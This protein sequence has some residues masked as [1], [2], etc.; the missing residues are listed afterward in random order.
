[1][2]L[3]FCTLCSVL[4]V[5]AWAGDLP[6]AQATIYN[7]QTYDNPAGPAFNQ[8]L[9][10]NNNGTIAGYYGSGAAGQP[11]NGYILNTPNTYTNENF[12]GS[13]QTQVTGINNIGTTVGF[14]SNS[15]TGTDPNFG[16]VDNR[17][18]FSNVNDPAVSSTPSVNQLLGVNDH[19]VAVGFYMDSNGNS[20]SYTYT[21]ASNSFVPITY[22]NAVS[23]TATAINN[24]SEIGGF[25]TNAGGATLGFIDS[26]GTFS[27]LNAPNATATM[28]FGLN[29]YGVLVGQAT[30]GG[31]TDGIAYNS[32]NDLWQIINDPLGI[33]TTTL[34]G[35]ND[36]GSIVGFYVDALG[37]TD[38]LLA[39]PVS[40]TPE[41][42]T[43]LLF[44][45]GLIFMS[46]LGI[47]NRQRFPEKA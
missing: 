43:G 17:G 5:F 46:V 3:R 25:Y 7:F 12:P 4:S 40:A 29:N 35:I 41:L 22:S 2:K 21:I 20:H 26:N 15:N 28:F 45:T 18:V 33:G 34:N 1:M 9:G 23:L 47:R 8:L 19:N 39:T 24:N 36:K 37:N 38:G 32:S 16:F 14:W 11:N 13:A 30:I 42:P 44:G 31:A 10:I 27:S 6:L